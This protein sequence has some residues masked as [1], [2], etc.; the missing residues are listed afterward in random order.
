V[1]ILA[2]DFVGMVSFP[3]KRQTVLVVHADAVPASLI[4]F[5]GLEPGLMVR[6]LLAGSP[7]SKEA[8]EAFSKR[9][10]LFLGRESSRPGP[11]RKPRRG[12][13]RRSNTLLFR[14]NPTPWPELCTRI[15][16]L[17]SGWAEYFSFGFTGQADDAIGWHVRERV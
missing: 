11:R 4:S 2:A 3:A 17:L 15:N 1:I 13:R 14:G 12:S 6:K 5:E 8:F 10:S 9:L 16:R 7:P